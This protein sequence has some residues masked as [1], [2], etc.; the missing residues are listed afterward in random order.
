MSS[1]ARAQG[2]DDIP[3]KIPDADAK[4]PEDWDDEDDGEWEPPLVANPEYKGP[5]K[6]KMI[7]NPAYKGKWVAPE[8]DNPA[9]KDDPE[10]YKFD[11]LAAVG[12]ELWQVKAGSIFD[13][14]VVTDDAA[15]ARAFAE[16]TWGASKAAEKEA[17]DKVKEEERKAAEEAAKKAEEERKAAA[18]EEAEE[19]YEEEEG[20][21]EAPAKDEL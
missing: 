11:D 2:Y 18:A 8:I 21:E 12:F 17:F 1:C 5:W 15:Y 9:F 19:E 16:K 14:I 7:D 10:M 13:N 3:E 6:Q 4:K 20:E